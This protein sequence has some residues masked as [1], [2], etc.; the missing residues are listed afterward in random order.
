MTCVSVF[1]IMTISSPGNADDTHVVNQVRLSFV[2]IEPDS[3]GICWF[4]GPKIKG[5]TFFAPCGNV[6]RYTL[7]SPGE[8]KADGF[9]GSELIP[10]RN[11]Q[12]GLKLRIPGAIAVY[13]GL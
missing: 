7:G 11:R 3:Q 5:R 13:I 10:I 1:E 8:G 12:M 6:K 9:S 4:C 2:S